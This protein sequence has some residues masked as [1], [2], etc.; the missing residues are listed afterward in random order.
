MVRKEKEQEAR[1]RGHAGKK[2]SPSGSAAGQGHQPGPGH[3]DAH[4]S[5]ETYVHKGAHAATLEEAE[6]TLVENCVQENLYIQDQI[7]ESTSRRDRLAYEIAGSAAPAQELDRIKDAWKEA[8]DDAWRLQASARQLD[9]THMG[10]AK[11]LRERF[12]ADPSQTPDIAAATRKEL[13]RRRK[14]DSQAAEEA[15]KSIRKLERLRRR[16]A[17]EIDS[18]TERLEEEEQEMC[19]QSVEADRQA[20]EAAA[21]AAGKASHLKKLREQREEVQQHKKDLLEGIDADEEARRAEEE[22]AR[23]RADAK[24]DE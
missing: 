13:D 22:A 5:G 1:E 16:T 6:E 17:K 8:N 24:A 21:V 10:Q 12:A 7:Q 4:L 11:E 2:G 23:G 15:A 14:E 20:A 19:R 9:L 3:G 18:Q